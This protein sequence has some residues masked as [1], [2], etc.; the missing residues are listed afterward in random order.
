MRI[1]VCDLT[2][3]SYVILLTALGTIFAHDDDQQESIKHAVVAPVSKRCS[4]LTQDLHVELAKQ[5][6]IKKKCTM[7]IYVA[8]TLSGKAFVLFFACLLIFSSIAVKKYAQQLPMVGIGFE[9][10]GDA[11]RESAIINVQSDYLVSV[12]FAARGVY[13]RW[14]LKA[15]IQ[16]VEVLERRH[17][18]MV[19]GSI[20][21]PSFRVGRSEVVA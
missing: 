21:N 11:I 12:F 18:D 10:C 13:A 14:R 8:R 7:S 2:C 19:C 17:G 9:G 1:R 16:V 15:P 5:Q 6:Q 4:F 3:G 20:Q